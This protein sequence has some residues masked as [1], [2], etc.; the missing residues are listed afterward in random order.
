MIKAGSWNILYLLCVHNVTSIGVVK[1][2]AKTFFL[3]KMNTLG[4][5][6]MFIKMVLDV[7]G[8]KVGIHQH[9]EP[10]FLVNPETSFPTPQLKSD[11]SVWNPKSVTKNPYFKTISLGFLNN[12]SSSCMW[13]IIVTDNS[14]K[15]GL[16]SAFCD[17]RHPK[18]SHRFL[19]ILYVFA[20][21]PAANSNRAWPNSILS[22]EKKFTN[23]SSV[24]IKIFN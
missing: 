4:P 6:F 10:K 2:F 17:L 1:F 21:L 20:S 24:P 11:F 22:S 12:L 5:I 3:S 7:G 23:E 8:V 13:L 18:L 15:I 14:P 16:E 19:F 9:L